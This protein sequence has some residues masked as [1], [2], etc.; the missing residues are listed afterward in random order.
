M[1]K[2]IF[3]LLVF[4][5][6]ISALA[7]PVTVSYSII[8]ADEKVSAQLSNEIESRLSKAEGISISQ[9]LSSY[10]LFVFAQQDVGDRINNKG[11]SFAIA[12]V[13][14]TKSYYVAS[15]LLDSNTPNI[16]ELQEV[17]ISM[18]QEEGFMKYLNVA[19]I[20]KLD[21]TNLL[22]LVDKITANFLDRV[23]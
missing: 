9:R 10:K 5:L 18:V 14:N 12:H 21:D 17:L 7:E 4:G 16:Q 20:D 22:L 2:F 15:K 6:S 1:L 13:D 8:C 3:S 11:W 23:Q 19:H